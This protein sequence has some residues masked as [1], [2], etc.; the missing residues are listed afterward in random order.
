ML[1]ELEYAVEYEVIETDELSRIDKFVSLLFPQYSRTLVQKLI[2]Q[3]SLIV[4]GK[5]TK[6]NYVVKVNDLIQVTEI[7]F[8]EM[9]LLPEPLD[10][11]IVYED[12][13][14]LVV[15]K[16]SGMVV[17]PA[18]GNYEHTLVNGLLYHINALS[19]GSHPL[20]PGIV[21]RIDKDTSGLLMVAKNDEAHRIL[22]DELK[23]KVTKREYIALVAGRINNTTGKI[24]APIGRDFKDRKKMKV[25]DSGRLAVT[26]FTVLE[27]FED[28]T[29]VKCVLETGRTHQIRVHMAFIGHPVIGDPVYSKKGSDSD[30]G[31]YLHAA[32]LG[33]THP[34]TKEYLEFSSPLPP[35]FETKLQKYR[36]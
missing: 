8:F 30:F 19:S 16:P 33:F 32:V 29:L 28:A 24:D 31:Q 1:T 23:A 25:S 10:L 36:K 5:P 20:R 2:T 4:N 9:D 6:S 35:D 18:P 21:H 15:D 17:H 12:D 14:V 13:D 26:H 34:R 22:A 11:N 7:P 27:R 3:E